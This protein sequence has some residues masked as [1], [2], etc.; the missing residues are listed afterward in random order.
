MSA[1]PPPPP[2]PIHIVHRVDDRT[3]RTLQLV[4]SIHTPERR[5]KGTKRKMPD[6]SPSA[7]EDVTCML[8]ELVPPDAVILPPS[9]SSGMSATL[10]LELANERLK[11]SNLT[12]LKSVRQLLANLNFAYGVLGHDL[13]VVQLGRYKVESTD[14]YVSHVNVDPTKLSLVSDPVCDALM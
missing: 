2:P 14:R 7:K 10:L 13:Q 8:A 12:S 1:N 9:S 11:S 6:S 5:T 4:E 3:T